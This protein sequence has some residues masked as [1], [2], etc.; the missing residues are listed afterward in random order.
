MM[1]SVTKRGLGGLLLPLQTL[2]GYARYMTPSGPAS[3][4]IPL[5]RLDCLRIVFRRAMQDL[6]WVRTKSAHDKMEA[7][8]AQVSI[9]VAQQSSAPERLKAKQSS[10]Y[11]KAWRMRRTTA[12]SVRICLRRVGSDGLSI[13]LRAVGSLDGGVV[14]SGSIRDVL[15]A[16]CVAFSSIRCR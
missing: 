5:P 7:L 12:T 1:A 2:E 14:R 9:P 10:A 15:A 8:A 6:C 4:E 11:R 3:A 13:V 16:P